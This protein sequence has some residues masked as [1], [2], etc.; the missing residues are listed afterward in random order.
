MRNEL[1]AV[2][3]SEKLP[4]DLAH[5]YPVFL[6]PGVETEDIDG[7]N[8]ASAYCGYHR[9]FGS[10][11]DQTVYGDLPYPPSNGGCDT[12]QAPNGNLRADGKVSTFAHELNEAITDPLNPQYG[13]FDGKGNE[14]GDMCDDNYGGAAGVDQRHEPERYRVQPGHQRA[15][16]LHP[17]AVQQSGV[18][19]VRGG[20]RLCTQ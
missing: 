19:Q 1:R 17:G 14:I 4:T 20:Q 9:A 3:S 5:F 13:W 7:T 2:T 12:G 11:T 8:S 6:P 16:V 18:C 15:Q 10:G